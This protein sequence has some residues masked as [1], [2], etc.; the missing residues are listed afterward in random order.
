MPKVPAPEQKHS[1][2]VDEASAGENSLGASTVDE[3]LDLPDPAEAEIDAVLTEFGGDARAAIA[4]LLHDLAV[5]AADAAA[6]TS[7]G[8]VRGRI[9]SARRQGTG[10]RQGGMSRP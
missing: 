8:Y 7:R 9:A 6:S 1:G 5:L 10:L 2:P 4:A 3:G